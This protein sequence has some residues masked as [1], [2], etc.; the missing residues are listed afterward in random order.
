METYSL[1]M[2][3]NKI[4]KKKYIGITCQK[5]VSARW[6]NGYGYEKSPLFNNAI[7]KY[8]WDNFIHTILF[9]NLTKEEAEKLEYE[10][11]KKYMSNNKKYGY[12]IENGGK[13]SKL[14]EQQKQH[15]RDINIGKHHTEETKKKM[16][17]S[18]KGTNYRE[19]TTQS[20]QFKEYRKKQ[21]LGIKNPNSKKIKQ[22]TLDGIFIKE[23]NYMNEAKQEL[24]VK[25][26]CHISDCCRG[27]RNKAYGYIWKYS[28]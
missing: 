14:S 26:T 16:S 12:N 23:Y 25:S 28:E 5:P 4:N 3:E 7:K 21:W 11:I 15:L 6:K 8:G 19:G 9:E 1:Y 20:E 22:Y 18:H 24:N 13:V 10:Y 17:L 27:L 2:H